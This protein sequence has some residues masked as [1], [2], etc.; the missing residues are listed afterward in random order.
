[1]N[2]IKAVTKYWHTHE[3]IS[4][5]ASRHTYR[6]LSPLYNLLSQPTK[7]NDIDNTF[8][9][10]KLVEEI[11]VSNVMLPKRPILKLAK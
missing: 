8:C 5:C 1:M 7:N 11:N 2:A 10:L 3:S 6:I 9:L 4:G